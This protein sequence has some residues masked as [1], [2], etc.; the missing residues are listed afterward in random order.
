MDKLLLLISRALNG[1]TVLMI[2]PVLNGLSS[3]DDSTSSLQLQLQLQLLTD[4]CAFVAHIILE[5]Y[6]HS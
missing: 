1:Y 2:L 6:I 4:I 5:I 3:L